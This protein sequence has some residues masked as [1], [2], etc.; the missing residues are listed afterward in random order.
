[1]FLKKSCNDFIQKPGSPFNIIESELQHVV[2]LP[3][4]LEN[5]STKDAIVSTMFYCFSIVFLVTISFHKRLQSFFMS[6]AFFFNSKIDQK[7][8]AFDALAYFHT[9][10]TEKDIFQ[11]SLPA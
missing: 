8:D 10:P 4:Y 9:L 2:A 11:Y 5:V 6:L 1:M 7:N 3:S